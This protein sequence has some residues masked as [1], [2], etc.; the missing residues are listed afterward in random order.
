[1]KTENREV[2]VGVHWVERTESQ[3]VQAMG[4]ASFLNP[5]YGT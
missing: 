1:M 3:H 4:W 2:L 5:V